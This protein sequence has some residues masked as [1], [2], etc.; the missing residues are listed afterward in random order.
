M[1]LIRYFTKK[2]LNDRRRVFTLLSGLILTLSLFAGI[3]L[4]VNRMS[5]LMLDEIY[6]DKERVDFFIN[7]GLADPIETSQVLNQLAEEGVL[8]TINRSVGSYFWLVDAINWHWKTDGFGVIYNLPNQDFTPVLSV[9]EDFHEFFGNRIQLIDGN[10]SITATPNAAPDNSTLYDVVVSEKFLNNEMIPE[11]QKKVGGVFFNWNWMYCKDGLYDPTSYNNINATRALELMNIYSTRYCRI[12]GIVDS[13][14]SI[15]NIESVAPLLYDG[16]YFAS[17][18][19]RPSIFNRIVFKFVEG[20]IYSKTFQFYNYISFDKSSLNI[21]NPLKTLNYISNDKE[22]LA[23]YLYENNNNVTYMEYEDAVTDIYFYITSYE[24]ED[25]IKEYAYWLQAALPKFLIFSSPVIFLGIYILN[26]SINHTINTRG[27][28]ISSLKSRGFSNG[29]IWSM[30]IYENVF[31]ALIASVVSMFFGEVLSNILDETITMQRIIDQFHLFIQNFP[32][33]NYLII[34]A[35]GF[36]I[37]TTLSILPANKILNLSIDKMAIQE[38]S[39]PTDSSERKILFYNLRLVAMGVFFTLGLTT[40][41]IS[42][43]ENSFMT[44]FGVIVFAITLIGGI[45]IMSQLARLIPY[46]IEKSFNNRW[47]QLFI[48]SR[49]MRRLTKR[50][51]AAFVVLSLAMAFG[52]ISSGLISTSSSY[53]AA[54]AE[55]KTGSD[56][57]VAIVDSQ[58]NTLS[59]L[60]NFQRITNMSHYPEV[61]SASMLY[62]DDGYLLNKNEEFPHPSYTFNL[63]KSSNHFRFDLIF[64][65]SQ[66][67]IETGY[68]HNYYLKSSSMSNTLQKMAQNPNK[69]CIVSS[70]LASEAKLKK[71][72][73]IGFTSG[74]TIAEY[75][76]QGN[77]TILDIANYFPA[78]FQ[79]IT[80]KFVIVDYSLIDYQNIRFNDTSF[81]GFSVSRPVSSILVKLTDE[82]KKLESLAGISFKEKLESDTYNIVG[83]SID[84]TQTIDN[85][86]SENRDMITLLN[87]AKLDFFYALIVSAIGFL[88]VLEIKT[89]EKKN[90]IG[91]LKA[92]GYGHRETFNLIMLDGVISILAASTAGLIIGII[93]SILM[94]FML[95]PV[96]SVPN[97]F[98]LSLELVG[99]QFA[100]GILGALVGVIIP[101]YLTKRF[102]IDELIKND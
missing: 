65:D 8:K 88:I 31:T 3:S 99:I 38:I 97:I 61:E 32:L 12:A 51:S 14:S 35:L 64:I 40:I 24:I 29:Q 81:I 69:T 47:S 93:C 1:T 21:N 86:L 59:G 10:W 75:I 36:A 52:I 76:F 62:I 55:F 72:M 54:D 82:Y 73:D 45:S 101:A 39:S 34:F 42:A 5:G 44:L 83:L 90:E 71:N 53:Y 70:N 22:E 89:V 26:F 95:L 66:S 9:N 27:K 57:N 79:G 77:T 91:I 4:Y 16:G 67:L 74:F 87:L 80:E 49:E 43:L 85:F 23:V 60:R 13:N 94:N 46:Y 98:K 6:D 17:I 28:E 7:T 30:F 78:G 84:N 102:S 19:L 68:F 100:L 37:I 20:G 11:N 48:I 96:L 63:M 56:V 58:W 25:L 15:F 50:T 33:I 2:S 92:I 18:D 41:D